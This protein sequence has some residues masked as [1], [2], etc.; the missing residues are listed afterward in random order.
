MLAREVLYQLNH[1]RS[2][3]SLLPSPKCKVNGRKSKYNWSLNTGLLSD[4]HNRMTQG[5][6]SCS[7]GESLK[8]GELGV[9]Q[10]KGRG[11]KGRDGE[12]ERERQRILIQF[13]TV[14]TWSPKFIHCVTSLVAG[15][16]FLGFTQILF[17][18]V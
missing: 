10:E 16:S 3:S 8:N 15:K 6:I 18:A 4:A 13:C 2:L 14:I 17:A 7:G 12:K 1:L 5:K 9:Q 11:R